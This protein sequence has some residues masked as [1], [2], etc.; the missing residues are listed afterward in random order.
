MLWTDPK[1]TF[2]VRTLVKIKKILLKTTGCAKLRLTV[3]L[4]AT[5]DGRKL[6][7]FL[8]LKRKTVPKSESFPKDVIVRAQEKGW[9]T[10]E[11]ML[12]WLKLVWSCR[13]G[14]FL[15]Q[16]SMLVLDAFKEHVTDSVKDQL[17]KMKTELVV[18]PGGMTSVLQPMDVS[19]NKSFKDR[20]R[21][22]YLT[23]IADPAREL[24][25]TGKIKRA[26]PSEVARWV[27]AAWK[28]IPESIIVR[29][30]KKCCISNAL[31]GSED[32]I[33]WKG[34]VEEKDDS[35]WVENMDNDSV[36][37][38]DGESGMEF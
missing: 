28:A 6:P 15:N 36:M 13:P 24:T 11:L 10:E 32:D 9:M 29:S 30:F 38:D 23:W 33:L 2:Y 12:E 21:Q 16:L 17:R 4:A 22:R 27:L 31:D 20:L 19:I 1:M 26:A 14:A 34:D 8:I 18:I 35:D 7:P 3:M 25:Q 5:A 37:S